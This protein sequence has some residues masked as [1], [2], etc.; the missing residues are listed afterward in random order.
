MAV[1]GDAFSDTVLCS[2][3]HAIDT[4]PSVPVQAAALRIVSLVQDRDDLSR[5]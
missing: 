4:R 1:S 5:K 3:H 2:F